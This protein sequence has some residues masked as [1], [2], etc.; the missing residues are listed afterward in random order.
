[1]QYVICNALKPLLIVCCIVLVGGSTLHFPSPS[2]HPSSFIV[3]SFTTRVMLCN[4]GNIPRC[5]FCEGCPCHHHRHAIWYELRWCQLSTLRGDRHASM[6]YSYILWDFG[7]CNAMHTKT[8]LLH[9]SRVLCILDAGF[10]NWKRG[11]G[12]VVRLYSGSSHT[13]T[14]ARYCSLSYLFLLINI[15]T[16]VSFSERW[17]F[18]ICILEVKGDAWEGKGHRRAL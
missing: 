9:R 1:M 18:P 2:I 15:N 17:H 7:I 10:S 12:D 11:K 5:F 3:T 13:W 16:T 14:E 4:T 8:N 6:Y